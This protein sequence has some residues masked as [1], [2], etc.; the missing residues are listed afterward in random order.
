MICLKTKD[1]T[2]LQFLHGNF[3]KGNIHQTT[4][5]VTPLRPRVGEGNVQGIEKSIGYQRIK[6]FLAPTPPERGIWDSKAFDFSIG[7]VDP[8]GK[9]LDTCKE[10]GWVQY[11]ALGQELSLR[12]TKIALHSGEGCS[13]TKQCLT[14]L[15][16]ALIRH[17]PPGNGNQL[18]VH[19]PGHGI[20]R[21][22]SLGD[23]GPWPSAF[24]QRRID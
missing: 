12:G 2:A 16:Q 21:R 7:P 3:Q 24:P 9:A 4:K 15:G 6:R 14:G 19:D 23:G 10:N 13:L 8:I 22:P 18:R 20:R 5:P 11:R 17:H 1:T